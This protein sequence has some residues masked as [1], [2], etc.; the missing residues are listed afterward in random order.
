MSI[1]D[2]AFTE[3]FQLYAPSLFRY[4]VRLS[5]DAD[6]AS[7]LMQETFVRLHERGSL[8]DDVRAWLVTVAAN[9]LRDDRR[10]AARRAEL[11][12][13]FTGDLIPSQSLSPAAVLEAHERRDA[14][15]AALSTLSERER[16]LLLL[17]HEGFS[18][19]EIAAATN[20]TASSVGTLLVRATAAFHAACAD[21][22]HA[23]A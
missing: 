10:T 7:D 16:Q 19:R 3:V 22:L 2:A 20:V 11:A 6:S 23:L 1:S 4:L 17:R 9:L 15:R 8:P 18:Y 5:G 14:V 13:R 12:K 21:R